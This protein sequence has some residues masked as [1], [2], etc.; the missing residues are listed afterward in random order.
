[1]L[2]GARDTHQN[3]VFLQLRVVRV[4]CV[5][6]G[7]GGTVV[8]LL[9]PVPNSHE[10]A[11]A[12]IVPLVELDLPSTDPEFLAHARNDEMGLEADVSLCRI[13]GLLGSA[14]QATFQ[15]S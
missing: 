9:V 7:H 5:S 14:W 10:S 4:G 13:N 12:K 8:T 15:I 3:S 11:V 1:M 2:R 6:N